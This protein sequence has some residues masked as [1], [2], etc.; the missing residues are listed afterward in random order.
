MYN[1]FLCRLFGCRSNPIIYSARIERDQGTTTPPD[2]TPEPIRD[3]T[4]WAVWK[5]YQLEIYEIQHNLGLSEP[6]KQMHVVASPMENNTIVTVEEIESNGFTI[7]TWSTAATPKAS[8][9]M[10]IAVHYP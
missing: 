4:G 2:Q 1:S 7:S 6:E 10:F 5:H 3:I 8:A 9:F